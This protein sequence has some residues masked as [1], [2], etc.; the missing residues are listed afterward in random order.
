MVKAKLNQYCLLKAFAGLCVTF[1]LIGASF[2]A[3]PMY[4]IISLRP[5]TGGEQWAPVGVGGMDW[6]PNGNMAVCSWGGNQGNN[7]P[8]PKREGRLFIL[9]GVVDAESPNDVQVREL[10]LG[11]RLFECQGLRVV[12]G[13][14]Y[15]LEKPRIFKVS[16]EGGDGNFDTFETS[17]FST[18]WYIDSTQWH[19]FALNLTFDGDN[20]YF[21]TASAWPIREESVHRAATI[22]VPMDDPGN[23][24]VLGGG[25]RNP[26]GLGLG[27][28]GELF[29]TINQGEYNPANNMVNMRKDRYFGM[30][31]TPL[32]YKP[33]W[34]REP[35]SWRDNGLNIDPSTPDHPNKCWPVT[36]W[37]DH[38]E[39]GSSPGEPLFVKQGPYKGQMFV[40]DNGSVGGIRRVFLE[41]IQGEYQGC[42]F[43]FI[44][45]EYTG[46]KNGA[47]TNAAGI[48]AGTNRLLHGPKGA[49][50]VGGVGGGDN[51]IANGR[52][53]G[54][55]YN[56]NWRSTWTGLQRLKRN[57]K[58]LFEMYA[59]RSK[60]TGFEIEF[61]QPA[62]NSAENVNNYRLA[63]YWHRRQEAYGAGHQEDKRRV[64]I[65]SVSLSSDKMRVQVTLNESDIVRRNEYRFDLSNIQSAEGE[66][67]FDGR[68]WYTLNRIGPADVLGCKDS[69][70]AGYNPEADYDDGL[71]CGDEVSSSRFSLEKSDIQ[72]HGKAIIVSHLGSHHVHV[73]DI[74]GKRVATFKGKGPSSY[75]MTGLKPGVYYVRLTT[76]GGQIKKTIISFPI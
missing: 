28:E 6:L 3:H 14:I 53:I 63:T 66:N 37:F 21:N 58:E 12:D 76:K 64:Q 11:R 25:I 48:E 31:T 52:G 49:L 26:D 29:A 33:D 46:I 72:I 50:Y 70:K 22:K 45:G 67:L 10:D 41:R 44:D 27:P 73:V 55:S 24:E 59:V 4:D 30:A 8:N 62:S 20:F 2:A 16:D 74:R 35:S 47:N 65:Q 75:S 60:P 51:I 19:H 34:S 42:V 15:V 61:T 9:E 56:W 36:V 54:G 13:D 39:T 32:R 57:G 7:N 38:R 40:C 68:A 43:Y 71:Q 69:T 5:Q 17:T 18:G 23:F 1:I